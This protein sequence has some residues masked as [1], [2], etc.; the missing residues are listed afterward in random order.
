MTK[1]CKVKQ[2]TKRLNVKNIDINVKISNV[3]W[4]HVF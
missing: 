3:T 1:A 4:N 2:R